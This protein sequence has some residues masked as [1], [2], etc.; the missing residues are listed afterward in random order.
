LALDRAEVV[1]QIYHRVSHV[2]RPPGWLPVQIICENCG[3]IGTT[4]ATDWDGTTV[5]YHCSPTAVEWAQGCGHTGRIAP[6]HG[7]A[8]LPFNLDWAA[9]WSHFG[10]TI[11][12]CGKDLATAGGSRERS[13]AIS[14][15]VYEREPPRNVA[16]EFLN[17]GGRKMSTS[18]GTGAAAHTI[19]EVV[20]PE[21]LRFLFLRPR[22]NTAI[23][24]DPEGTDAIPRL[25][26]E[27]DRIADATAG[28]EV[29]GELPPNPHRLFALSLVDPDANVAEEAAAFRP[30]FGHLALLVQI[31]GVDLEGRI[32]AEKGSD[33]T[34]REEAILGARVEAARAWL[35]TYAPERA[36]IEVQR[37]APAEIGRLG[38][39]QRVYLAALAAGAER[40]RP[41][42]GEEWQALIFQTALD[43]ELPA[44]RA[45]GALY[46]AFLGRTNGPRAGW[47]LASL[48][49]RFVLG[50]LHGAAGRAA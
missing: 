25:F 48:D 24:F 26:D 13:D 2:E 38:D 46:V 32:R 30:A 21:Q 42:T 33:L 28:R 34:R 3:R 16:Y 40:E 29:K 12:G 10:I 43:G 27:F 50:R 20:P 15:E 7:N 6:F 36:R 44:G 17:V 8:K 11:E 31:P 45:F 39:D 5:A 14:R 23:E 47:L 35:A 37:D 18:K 1:R 9:K 19:A 49:H 4:I 41:V 22:P